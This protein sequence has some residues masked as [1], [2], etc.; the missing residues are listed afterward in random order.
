M[1]AL[2][3]YLQLS[4]SM[5]PFLLIFN[6]IEDT[7]D[8]ISFT[9]SL[10]WNGWRHFGMGVGNLSPCSLVIAMTD[11]ISGLAIWNC[12]CLYFTDKSF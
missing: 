2:G 1:Q 3:Q 12:L 7:V 8:D 5:L 6:W 10:L 11:L 9:N 4:N